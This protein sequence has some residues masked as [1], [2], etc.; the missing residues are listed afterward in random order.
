MRETVAFAAAGGQRPDE[1]PASCWCKT[2]RFRPVRGIPGQ[3]SRLLLLRSTVNDL[4]IFDFDLQLA[5]LPG[6]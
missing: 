6:L 5:G 3:A 4:A 1:N 2:L